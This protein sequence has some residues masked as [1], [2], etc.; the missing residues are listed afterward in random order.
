MP[1]LLAEKSYLCRPF[2]K[3]T[4]MDHFSEFSIPV[5]GLRDGEYRYEYQLDR[6][7]F[8]RFEDA[9]IG[10]AQIE[11]VL[12]LE[13]RSSMMILDIDLNGVIAAICD[14]CT[15]PIQL[16]IESSQELIVKHSET[17]GEDD[18]VVFIHPSTSHFNVAKYFYEFCVLALPIVNVYDCE[19]DEPRPCNF[20]VLDKLNQIKPDEGD[21]PFLDVLKNFEE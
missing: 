4:V 19:N 5:L 13:K 2:A 7:F 9:P 16:P 8:S 10:D 12:L 11:V 15:A 14:K 17:P 20:E 1:L 3:N 6:S 18:E 21:N